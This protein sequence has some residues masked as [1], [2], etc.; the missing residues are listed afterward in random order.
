MWQTDVSERL[1]ADEGWLDRYFQIRESGSTVRTELV[2]GLTTFMVMAYIIFVNPSILS[3]AGIPDLQKLGPG[4]APTLAATCLVAGVMTLAMGLWAKY[5]LA[6]APGMGLNAVVAFQLIVGVKLP[7]QAAMGVIFL[8]GL[9][10][11]IL[12]LTGFRE[13][14][15]HAIPM[16]L[17]RA[18]GVGIGL[19]IFFIGLVDGELI[20][21]GSKDLG[22][23]VTW[24]TSPR[25]P[26]LVSIFGLFLT[27][28][29][30]ARRVK[31]A[32]LIG[33]LLSTVLAI[34]VNAAAGGTAWTTPGAA[35]DTD[36]HLRGARF[37]HPRRRHQLR[38]LRAPG[39]HRRGP[40][41][42]LVDAL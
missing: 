40:D 33:I 37:L 20:L 7:W 30:L 16:S 4:F 5:P 23:P 31:G 19:F 17:K 39:R 41:H 29:L 24:A 1:G 14:V 11:T 13:A 21:W 34:V 27:I 3:F 18:I 25:G 8:E 2:A 12:V 36:E 10:I 26:V 32:L 6:L 15:M 22:T 42:L 38:R 9:A 35:V 28:L